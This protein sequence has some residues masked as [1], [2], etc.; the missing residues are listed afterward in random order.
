[1][2]QTPRGRARTEGPALAL[3]LHRYLLCL[4]A[5]KPTCSAWKPGLTHKAKRHVFKKKKKAEHMW[6]RR[7]GPCLYLRP[8]A[9]SACLPR[10]T[11]GCQARCLASIRP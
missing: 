11:P 7:K 1:M 6:R 4:N 10:P 2:Q 8:R 3:D 5:D 9:D